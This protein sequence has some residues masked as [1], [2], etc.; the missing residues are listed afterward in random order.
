MR[1]PTYFISHGGG[2]WPWLKEGMRGAYDKLEA[3]LKELPRETGARPKAILAVS[4]HWEEQDFTVMSGATP[5]MLYDYSGF[6]EHT[7]RIRYGAPGSPQVA[8]RVQ[9]LL[10]AA[11]I[12]ARADAARGFDHGV[13]APLAVAYPEADVPV[14]QLSIRKDYD[15]EAHLAAGRALAPLRDEGVLIMASGLSYHNLRQ[16]D[17][18]ARVPSREFD[19]WLTGAVCGARSEER[20]RLLCDWQSAPS[21]RAAHP[22]EDHLIPL[23]VA[24][25]AAE[26]ETGVRVYHEDAFF[27]GI[28]V[29]SFRFG[30][31]AA[32]S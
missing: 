19:E 1:L 30:E 21:A 24:A 28:T 31:A 9:E 16:F 14:V 26:T 11:G 8:R 13:F 27:G 23:M 15:P 5:P 6:P 18:R 20:N 7:Y 3:S 29:S 25:G 32:A 17:E 12:G 22:R 4:G 10:A 2:P